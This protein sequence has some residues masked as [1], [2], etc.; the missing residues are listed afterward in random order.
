MSHLY[1]CVTDSEQNY[2]CFMMG[3]CVGANKCYIFIASTKYRYLSLIHH[4]HSI[5]H[6]KYGDQ[7]LVDKEEL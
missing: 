6:P 3:R 1:A 5:A 4:C 2:S 7:Y